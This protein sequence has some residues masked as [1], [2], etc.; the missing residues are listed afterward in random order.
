MVKQHIQHKLPGYEGGYG[1][2]QNTTTKETLA[3]RLWIHFK[4]VHG[5]ECIDLPCT[6]CFKKLTSDEKVQL[7][8]KNGCI[9]AQL[10]SDCLKLKE[11]S[12]EKYVGP[13]NEFLTEY[14]AEESN[15]VK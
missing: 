4:Y 14:L 2:V 7:P 13:V 10:C 8:M 3:A 1:K 6:N 5:L 9:L 12:L 11:I 15:R